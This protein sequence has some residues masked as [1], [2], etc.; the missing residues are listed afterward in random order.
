MKTNQNSSRA[1]ASQSGLAKATL[2]GMLGRISD[3]YGIVSRQL[4]SMYTS[5][6]R[7]H[8]SIVNPN[9]HRTA[10]FLVRAMH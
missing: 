9:F 3:K 6:L 1:Y 4:H 2:Y 5:G 8:F 7:I 10:G